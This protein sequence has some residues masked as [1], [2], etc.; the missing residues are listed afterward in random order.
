MSGF[1]DL[2]CHFLPAVDDGVRTD[3][4][5]VELLLALSAAGFERV[6]ATPHMRPGMFDND[7]EGLT[8]AFSRLEEVLRQSSAAGTI[9]KVALASEHY[10][11]ELVLRRLL[12]GE[13]LPYPGGRAVLLEF[14]DMDFLPAIGQRLFE[15]RRR[16][17]VPVIAHPERYRCFWKSHA[18]LTELV[19]AGAAALLDTAAL[20]GKYGKESQKAARRM[21]DEGVYTAACSDAHRPSDVEEVREGMSYIQKRFGD[22][23]LHRLLRLGP[24]EILEGT[25]GA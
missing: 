1:V 21:L 16:R 22:E 6:M 10:F 13:G 9:P 11:D 7:R 5:A 24:L 14:Y 17:L 8:Q 2:H 19:S 23:E 4:E 20:V 25:V 18:R 3:A 12:A 15:L